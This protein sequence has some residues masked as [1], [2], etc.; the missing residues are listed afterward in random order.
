VGVNE[1]L[2]RHAELR[3]AAD[4][5]RAAQLARWQEQRQALTDALNGA[6]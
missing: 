2:V 4:Q 3:A 5:A 6:G 1:A